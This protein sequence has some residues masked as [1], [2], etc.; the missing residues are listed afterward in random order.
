M[1]SLHRLELPAT[2]QAPSLSALT[3]RNAPTTAAW[4]D[5]QP[6]GEDRGT[7]GGTWKRGCGGCGTHQLSL[8]HLKEQ[9]G[10]LQEHSGGPRR[11]RTHAP[12]QRSR[13]PFPS[14]RG[15]RTRKQPGRPE[16][17]AS[18][19]R[20]RYV[21]GDP[22]AGSR[23]DSAPL[24]STQRREARRRG[25]GPA[26][27]TRRSAPFAM[28][29]RPSP[30]AALARPRRAQNHHIDQSAGGTQGAGENPARAVFTKEPASA[31]PAPSPTEGDRRHRTENA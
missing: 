14:R 8:R 1:P 20:I 30:G 17:A 22:R 2:K 16:R 18:E 27:R 10:A 26:G 24:P 28:N 12:R 21:R 13:R 11:R 4:G 9:P 29:V 7:G 6:R 5:A 15:P 25:E 19:T 31:S 23:P 3:P